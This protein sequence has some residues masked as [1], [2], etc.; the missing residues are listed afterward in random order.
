MTEPSFIL[1]RADGTRISIPPGGVRLGRRGDNDVVVN[2]SN[3]SRYHARI[4]LAAGKCWI[5]DENSA[6]G[7]L[8][9]GQL[10]P[11]QMEFKPGDTLHLGAE[12]FYLEQQVPAAVAAAPVS[13]PRR[14]LK[15]AV[16]IGLGIGLAA[17]LLV[18]AFA[19]GL[20]GGGSGLGFDRTSYTRFTD[21]NDVFSVEHPTDWVI[22]ENYEFEE[23]T[24]YLH[25]PDW[26]DDER[27]VLILAS[28]LF[29]AEL[30]F[31]ADLVSAEEVMEFL[32][33]SGELL[34]VEA[35][36]DNADISTR[37]ISGDPAA[38]LETEVEEDGVRYHIK[39]VSVLSEDSFALF[40][41][42]FPR[43]EW[44][45]NRSTIEH[46]ITSLRLE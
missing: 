20:L 44:N 23:F 5:R 4:L 21:A 36:F 13:A 31:G 27:G 1:I 38:V 35:V 22:E 15:P 2:G 29:G 16:G 14:K 34:G 10:V 32:V 7:T 24:T 17:I 45:A 25:D 37:S 39:I 12:A 28:P 11:G 42:A 43:S 40:I 30:L 6:L 46:M 33:M 41:A 3:I 9:N 26:E 8:L 18:A 19:T